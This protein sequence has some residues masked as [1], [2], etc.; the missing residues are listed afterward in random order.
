MQAGVDA[1]PSAD[2]LF[3][4]SFHMANHGLDVHNLQADDVLSEPRQ[5]QMR[6]VIAL[7]QR[8]R[9]TKV[10][11]EFNATKQAELQSRYDQ[12][13]HGE[14]PL[15]RDEIEQLALR[16]ACDAGLPGLVAVDWN[17][18]GPFRDEASLDYRQAAERNGQQAALQAHHDLGTR[19]NDQGQKVLDQG[20]ILDMLQ[21]LNSPQWLANNARAYHRIAMFGSA[22]DPIGANWMQLWFGRN[23]MIFDNIVRHTAP[24]DR[25]LVIY[26]AGHGNL[27]RQ[28]ARDSGV[29]RVQA[30]SDWLGTGTPSK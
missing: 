28:L 30:A 9:P 13:C 24:G 3:V 8:Y 27:L 17:E 22:Q 21:Y 1:A 26:G 25:V 20:S 11:V 12:S 29:Y 18:L 10:M 16:I 6:Q 7:L 15:G 23:Q 19:A 14:R 4:G 5:R 2:F